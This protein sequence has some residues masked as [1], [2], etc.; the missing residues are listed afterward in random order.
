[1]AGP[2][3]LGGR[4][5]TEMVADPGPTEGSDS[6]ARWIPLHVPVGMGAWTPE[7]HLL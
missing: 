2:G 1:M 5:N 6:V 3:S 4:V 7:P